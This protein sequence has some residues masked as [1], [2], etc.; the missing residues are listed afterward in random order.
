MKKKNGSSNINPEEIFCKVNPME[1]KLS[2]LSVTEPAK[3]VATGGA[4][5]IAI[6]INRACLAR[7]AFINRRFDPDKYPHPETLLPLNCLLN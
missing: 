6:G 5:R 1:G 3:P 2:G 7:Q 4:S